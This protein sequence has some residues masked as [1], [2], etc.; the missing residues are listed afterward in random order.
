MD[1][2]QVWIDLNNRMVGGQCKARDFNAQI[3]KLKEALKPAK[4]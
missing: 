4:Q 3:H 1:K 2:E